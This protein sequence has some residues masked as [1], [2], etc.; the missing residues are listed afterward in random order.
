MLVFIALVCIFFAEEKLLAQ[1]VW[2][3]HANYIS[4]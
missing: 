2:S 4:I 3:L 1:G